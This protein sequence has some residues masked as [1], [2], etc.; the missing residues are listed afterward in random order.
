MWLTTNFFE[1]DLLPDRFICIHCKKNRLVVLLQSGYTLAAWLILV[2]EDNGIKLLE[3][4][5]PPV[6]L[7]PE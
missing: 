1:I 2:S 7:I 4:W 3:R 6:F 5:F